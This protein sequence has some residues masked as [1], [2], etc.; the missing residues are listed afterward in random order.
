M[1]SSFNLAEKIQRLMPEPGVMETTVSN[2][3]LI[4]R[5]AIMQNRCQLIYDPCI[6]V[7]VQGRK[8]AFL[9]DENYIYDDLNYLVL[10][11]PLP[12][13]CKIMKASIEKPYLVM[14]IK[15]DLQILSELVEETQSLKG[16]PVKPHNNVVFTCLVW[17]TILEQYSTI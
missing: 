4:R 3:S 6:Y 13:E 5:N 15:I 16:Q 7:V 1:T 11:V 8:S 9:N 14:R 2:L 17:A 12:L 10:S